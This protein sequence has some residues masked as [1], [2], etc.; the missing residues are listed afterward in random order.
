M[1][2]S[3]FFLRIVS[4]T[5]TFICVNF[6][7]AG[8]MA[9]E[10]GRPNIV[11]ILCD[12]LGFGDMTDEVMPNCS[13]LAR[14]GARMKLYSQHTCL[15]TR[16]ALF[17]GLYPRRL[18][19]QTTLHTP[20]NTG[21]PTTHKILSEHL[22]DSGYNCAIF[23]KWHLGW[24]KRA[25]WPTRRGFDEFVGLL[26]GFMNSFG[27][28]P[29]GAPY[30]DGSL[31]HAHHNMHDLQFNEI[32]FRTST[33]STTVFSEFSKSFIRKQ[34]NSEDPFFLY[35]PFNAPHGPYSA[36]R[37]QV[38][39]AL[40]TGEF[41]PAYFNHME[42]FADGVLGS[43]EKRPISQFLTARILYR[44]MVY[45][46]DDA[47][48]EIY[49]ELEK[50]G[51]AENT[52]FVVC[53]DNGVGYTYDPRLEN[54]VQTLSGSS[55]PLRDGKGSPYEGGTRVANFILWPK[56]VTPG[57]KI[58]SNIWIGDLTAT[59]LQL[60]GVTETQFTL[61]GTSIIP[62]LTDDEELVRPRGGAIIMPVTYRTRQA[63]VGTVLFR[64][65]K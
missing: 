59:F 7:T 28:R 4:L 29:G 19:L 30:F 41:T 9:Q 38:L 16:T 63:A 3:N 61:D 60:A 55:G 32:P 47:I 1:L 64:N 10:D 11:F 22:D 26:S 12:D 62:A 51:K 34:K 25:Q 5:L 42:E 65:R 23:G 49:E 35:V 39:R 21:V 56:G 50:S 40:R 15:A 58:S 31:G 46:L 37:E 18:G 44:A 27:S 52:I 53:S 17:T 48:G 2:L 14:R 24:Q 13:D 43:S 33:Y 36:P 45:A 20:I 57:Q 6:L 8:L 54:P